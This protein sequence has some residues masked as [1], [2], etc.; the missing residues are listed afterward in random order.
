LV[1]TAICFL[2]PAPA[3]SCTH[4]FGTPVQFGARMLSEA[5]RGK[6]TSQVSRSRDY[7]KAAAKGTCT[8]HR[9]DLLWAK[10]RLPSSASIFA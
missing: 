8:R 10:G 9:L 5:V 6:D 1:T 7:L 4:R 2:S 3:N